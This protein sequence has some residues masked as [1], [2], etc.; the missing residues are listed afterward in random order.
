[1]DHPGSCH[2]LF[3]PFSGADQS[4]SRFYWDREGTLVKGPRTHTVS[5]PLL[6]RLYHKRC[7]PQNCRGRTAERA[8][9]D[10]G[11]WSREPPLQRGAPGLLRNRMTV[12]PEPKKKKAKSR[13]QPFLIHYRFLMIG[14]PEG[15]S[16]AQFWIA[17]GSKKEYPFVSKG[18]S[19]SLPE[20]GRSPPR[21]SHLKIA[22]I[23][24]ITERRVPTSSSPAS[25][26]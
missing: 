15:I 24:S 18:Y 8:D 20:V 13:A 22:M 5:S 12:N 21:I 4:S 2:Y 17:N 25:I 11:R 14:M 23:S 1:M 16:I 9:V 10:F 19:F 6:E 7:K 26:R 3:V